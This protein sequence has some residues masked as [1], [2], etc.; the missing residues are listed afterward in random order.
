MSTLVG[1]RRPTYFGMVTT[2]KSAS[3]TDPA[4]DSFFRFTEL[5]EGDRFFL[6]DND[7]GYTPPPGRRLDYVANPSPRSFAANVNQAIAHAEAADADLVFL[8]NDVIFS[9]G[10]LAPLT[11]RDDAILIPLCNQNVVYQ[12]RGLALKSAMDLEE[13]RGRED[14]YLAIVTR[15][16]ADAAMRG[17]R[18]A[19]MIPFFCFRLPRRVMVV[20]GP[21][22]ESFGIGG[23]EDIDYRIRAHI[24]GFQ[25]L[26]AAESY[27]LHFGGKSTWRGGEP[28]ADIKAR[29]AQYRRRLVEKWG[30]DIALLFLTHPA[31]RQ[32]VAE[33]G[34]EE[35]LKA[36]DYPQLTTSLLARRSA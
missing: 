15:H 24:A 28:D 36:G 4:L 12:H 7:G 25:V 20:L 33:L 35:L 9:P 11:S 22:D 10:W 27:V 30:M 29:N 19:L 6:I 23:G 31:G 1:S 17:V 32:R 18:H 21:F 8:N 3:Y 5:G 34:L 2:A 13:Y 16:G 14:D 26:L